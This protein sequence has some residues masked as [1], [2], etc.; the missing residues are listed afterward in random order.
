MKRLGQTHELTGLINKVNAGW[1]MIDFKTDEV[2][3]DAESQ[4]ART[5]MTVRWR[6]MLR[7][8]ATTQG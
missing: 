4:S 5:G 6:A 8:S 3:S 1:F 2:R 7:Q